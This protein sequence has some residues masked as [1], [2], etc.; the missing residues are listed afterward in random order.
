MYRCPEC[1][2]QPAQCEPCKCTKEG[3]AYYAAEQARP[4]RYLTPDTMIGGSNYQPA[5][6][7]EVVVMRMSDMRSPS[8]PY[9]GRVCRDTEVLYD[10]K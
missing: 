7:G 5:E 1:Q 6:K 10:P 9:S 4:V 2:Y 8:G 3:M